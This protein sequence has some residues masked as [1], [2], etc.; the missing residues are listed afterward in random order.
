MGLSERRAAKEFQDTQ[1]PPFQTEIQ[2]IVGMPVPIEV[3]W[4]ELA[5]EGQSHLYKESW[6][7]LYFKP[8]VEGLRQITRDQMGKDAL[9][10]G[11]KKIQIRNSKGAY[12]PETAISFDGGTLL[13]D[14]ALSNVQNTHERTKYVVE[15]VEKGL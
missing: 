6:P 4:E 3:A 1:F 7:E 15:I 2:K 9:K 8:I 14:H 11:L 5:K 13:V 12:Y 10:G